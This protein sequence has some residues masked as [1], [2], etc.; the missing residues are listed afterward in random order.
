VNLK[1][2]AMFCAVHLHRSEADSL[3]IAGTL[4]VINQVSKSDKKKCAIHSHRF[5][6]MI[7][8]SA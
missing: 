8:K 6:F 4:K 1:Q 2:Q 3:Y 5:N 7:Y